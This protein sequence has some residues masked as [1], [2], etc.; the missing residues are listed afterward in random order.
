MLAASFGARLIA[1]SEP[2][3]AGAEVGA[4]AEARLAAAV[5]ERLRQL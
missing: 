1:P 4:G 3:A 2:G 5:T